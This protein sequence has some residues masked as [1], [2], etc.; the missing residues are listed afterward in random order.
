MVPCRQPCSRITAPPSDYA[1]RCAPAQNKP[2]SRNDDNSAERILNVAQLN[3]GRLQ[4]RSAVERSRAKF[5]QPCGNETQLPT[6]PTNGAKAG[7]LTS[8]GPATRS[9]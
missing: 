7:W 4:R 8:E 2:T 3:P 5:A 1:P 9:A 6:F